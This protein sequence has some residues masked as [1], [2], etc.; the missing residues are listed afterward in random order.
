MLQA[1][2]VL[3]NHSIA[4]QLSIYVLS[5]VQGRIEEETLAMC[6]AAGYNS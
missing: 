3:S 5:L 4:V 2:T 1:S 6:S